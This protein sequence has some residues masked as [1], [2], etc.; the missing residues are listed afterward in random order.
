MTT[1]VPKAQS[2]EARLNALIDGA[3]SWAN[4]GSMSNG[5]TIG[6]TARYRLTMDGLLVLA[7][8]LNVGTIAD[9]TVIWSA[10]NGLPSGFRVV[11]RQK[12]IVA[13]TDHESAPGGTGTESA[14]V[15]LKTDGSVTVLGMAGAATRLN[16]YGV[17]PLDD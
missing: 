3:T 13:A 1:P 15:I 17:Y 7:W 12:V 8:D 6:T 14:A 5:W 16:V 9:G 10:A 11:N 2:V 4:M